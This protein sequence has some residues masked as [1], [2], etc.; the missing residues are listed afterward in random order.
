MEEVDHEQ[1]DKQHA[2]A[3]EEVLQ[4]EREYYEEI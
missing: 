1:A 4:A 3:I 2:E